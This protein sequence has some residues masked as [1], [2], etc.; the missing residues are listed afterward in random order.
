VNVVSLDNCPPQ[1]DGLNDC[2]VRE[3]LADRHAE[4]APA[5]L[6]ASNIDWGN[7][8]RSDLLN[9]R[10]RVVLDLLA[11]GHGTGEVAQA[12]GVSAPRAVQLTDA[13]GDAATQFFGADI[14]LV[15]RPTRK[16]IKKQGRPAG[17]SI[18]I[19]L[20]ARANTAAD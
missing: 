12:I 13:L 15:P 6:A 17:K 20:N 1:A 19:P 7:F 8:H 11:S 9:D 16:P 14:V 4:N 3:V 10:Q 5:E 18:Y 2:T